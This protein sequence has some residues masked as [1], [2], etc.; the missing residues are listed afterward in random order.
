MSAHP[1]GDDCQRP[2][3]PPGRCPAADRHRPAPPGNAR[4]V[5]TS[6]QRPPGSSTG[7][8]STVSRQ[9][10][11]AA[12]PTGSRVATVTAPPRSNAT[13]CSAADPVP[14]S[15]V[16]PENSSGRSR[17][18]RSARLVTSN[19]AAPCSSISGSQP[20]SSRREQVGAQVVVDGPAVVRVD[21]REV[22][23][24]A[25]LVDVG[26]AGS[27]EL[28]QLGGQGVRPSGPT[29]RVDRGDDRGVQLGIVV[30]RVHQRVQAFLESGVRV[31]PAGRHRGLPGGLLRV[32]VQPVPL[33]RP[34]TDRRLPDQVRQRLVAE[35]G[36]RV[37]PAHGGRP[38]VR[39]LGDHRDPGPDVLRA[40]GVVGG[41]RG[42]R[43]RPAAL[44]LRLDAVELL[45]G[46]RRTGPARR[47]PPSAR[48]AGTSGRRRSP[49][50]PW[51]SPCRRSAGTGSRS[52]SR[53]RPAGGRSRR[54]RRSTRAGR[55]APG[56]RPRPGTSRRPA[57]RCGTP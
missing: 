50:P 52:P 8:S 30:D 15:A 6:V 38:F 55:T 22:P 1:I 57:G 56:R 44:P 40:L 35:R 53:H 51:P 18:N 14:V 43:R 32:G 42:H 31:D 46:E 13:R 25:A 23:Q 10:P 54:S 39:N 45:R 49:R 16:Y 9:P 7:S 47:R 17:R 29:E 11:P 28:N 26:H 48:S 3:A 34:G 41:Q 36:Q 33:D 27:G 5:S 4:P 19:L 37:P 20:S 24:L 12:S 21:Q 2:A